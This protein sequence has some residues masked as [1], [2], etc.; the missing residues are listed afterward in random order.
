MH[1]GFQILNTLL[2]SS[3]L[4]TAIEPM[5]VDQALPPFEISLSILFSATLFPRRHRIAVKSKN[6]DGSRVKGDREHEFSRIRHKRYFRGDTRAFGLR[7]R[8]LN[9]RRRG[10]EGLYRRH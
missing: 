6:I 1:Y 2:L 3:R 8:T 10:Y 4:G 9:V 5:S 7:R